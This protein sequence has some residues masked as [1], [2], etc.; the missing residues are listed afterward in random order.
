[1]LH[2]I[3]KLRNTLN[4]MELDAALVWY[5]RDVLYYTGTAQPSVLAILPDSYRL[6]VK[7]GVERARRDVFIDL[8]RVEPVRG[9]ARIF[10]GLRDLGLKPNPRVGTELDVLPVSLWENW[11][12]L[13]PDWTFVSITPAILNQRQI[14]EEHE[15]RLIKKACGAIDAG[16]LR[17]MEVLR[18]GMTELEL[19]AELEDAHR[20][21]GHE[22]NYFM[23][24]PDFFMGR[25]MLS[26]GPDL[27]N[28]TGI[29]LSLTGV[30]LSAATPAGPSRRVIEKDELVLIDIPVMLEGYHA[31]HTRMYVAGKADPLEIRLHYALED[32][33]YYAS[34]NIRPG[35]TWAQCVSD[36][37]DFAERLGVGESFQNMQNGKKLHYI[38]HGVG[39][40]LNEPP[41]VTAKNNDPVLAGTV[42]ALEMQLLVKDRTAVK[43][44]DMML[45]G[46][47]KNEFL[48]KTPRRLFETD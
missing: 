31:D 37:T 23:R 33:F 46:E 18:P 27:L 36:V 28:S 15:V 14:K 39:L 44:E 21:A 30:G 42:M 8:D 48:A 35:K 24:H 6:F 16:H 1:M 45:I 17:T 9:M 38:G 4:E 41:L 2:R 40:E 43:M 32:I 25:G 10:D 26:S 29:A 20:R 12:K 34:E 47:E 5:S 11:Q 7:S 13:A 19:A 22:G 3:E